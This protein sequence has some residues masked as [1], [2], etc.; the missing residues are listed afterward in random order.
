MEDITELQR[1]QTKL[2]E[3][4]NKILESNNREDTGKDLYE[5]LVKQIANL[6]I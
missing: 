4:Q 6:T 3:E 1:E 2:Q 5:N